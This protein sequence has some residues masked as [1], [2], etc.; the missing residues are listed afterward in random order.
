MTTQNQHPSTCG[1]CLRFCPLASGGKY[2]TCQECKDQ[3]ISSARA[4][5]YVHMP[6]IQKQV[7]RPQ[8]DQTELEV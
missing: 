3:V 7:Q 5:C 2:G 4:G 1:T 6:R 8:V